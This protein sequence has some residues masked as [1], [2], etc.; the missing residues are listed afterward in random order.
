MLCVAET[1]VHFDLAEALHLFADYRSLKPIDTMLA[2]S[3]DPRP[4]ADEAF[5]TGVIAQAQGER[6][7][8]QLCFRKAFDM[9]KG[10]GYV[11]RA[12]ISA[13]ALLELADDD[14]VRSYISV[15]L[16][17]TTNYITKALADST[18][19]RITSLE[20][21]PT[22]TSLSR[23]QREVVVLICL[24]KTNKEIAQ[25]RHVGAQTIKNMLTKNVFPAFGVSSRAALVSAFIQ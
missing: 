22:F 9:F 7:H 23:S 15:E 11:R 10:L 2:S 24:G 16:A 17:G 12:V 5:I 3:G 6:D 4:A 1:C 13:T 25:W 18:D 19:D 14:E 21:H 8:A 20:R